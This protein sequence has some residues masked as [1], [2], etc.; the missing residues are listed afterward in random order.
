MVSRSPPRFP[1]RSPNHSPEPPP[2]EP[3]PS[4]PESPLQVSLDPTPIVNRNALF[5]TPSQ[6]ELS[7]PPPP[8]QNVLTG[9]IPLIRVG[10]PTPV[11]DSW[12][13]FLRPPSPE[14]QKQG[15]KGKIYTTEREEGA[16]KLTPIASRKDRL[17][18]DAENDRKSNI[19]SG[20]KEIWED[21]TD[22][23]GS[24]GLFEE[25][26]RREDELA[27][28][29]AMLDPGDTTRV[30]GDFEEESW[31]DTG[32]VMSSPFP[33]PD[34][35]REGPIAAAVYRH[36]ADVISE[37][38]NGDVRLAGGGRSRETAIYDTGT[39][40]GQAP[41]PPGNIED[42]ENN[43]EDGIPA[44]EVREWLAFPRPVPSL[45][46]TNALS[47]AVTEDIN[48]NFAKMKISPPKVK[49][50][51]SYARSA[52]SDTDTIRGPSE[53]EDYQVKQSTVTSRTGRRER[54]R[55]PASR[56]PSEQRLP[57]IEN[58]NEEPPKSTGRRGLR[59][60]FST[61][62]TRARIE[63]WLR[64]EDSPEE[65][66]S[67]DLNASASEMP[68]NHSSTSLFDDFSDDGVRHPKSTFAPV[69][70]GVGDKAIQVEPRYAGVKG[71]HTIVRPLIPPRKSS[72][73]LLERPLPARMPD[74]KPAAFKPFPDYDDDTSPTP[75][76]P[77][78][79]ATV[80]KMEPT[81]PVRTSSRKK[82]KI[83]PV[84]LPRIEIEESKKEKEKEKE[85]V[86]FRLQRS[87]IASRAR[88]GQQHP[89]A[90]KTG[91]K[92]VAVTV[93]A[94]TDDGGA[95]MVGMDRRAFGGREVVKILERCIRI[96]K[97]GGGT[98]TVRSRGRS[99]IRR[100]CSQNNYG[101]Q[102]TAE[103]NRGRNELSHK[104]KQGLG[105]LKEAKQLLE[106]HFEEKKRGTMKRC[107]E[108]L[109]LVG[110]LLEEVA[111]E[112]EGN[113]VDG[114]AHRVREKVIALKGEAE[115]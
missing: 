89:L 9:G 64:D 8:I 27:K 97:E 78:R 112:V 102:G 22:D 19:A 74:I 83:H 105:Q 52:H 114:E 66:E 58:E 21:P 106:M 13:S 80:A 84:A 32:A 113:M 93:T 24:E 71:T 73:E 39:Y 60:K 46:S 65:A 96:G 59:Y 37:P 54:R 68:L 53:D 91:G 50:V 75:P 88:S 99:R 107:E 82:I 103:R 6:L 20:E 33:S 1:R 18:P 85:D 76:R 92:A 63:N 4:C 26:K 2:P 31:E 45:S 41:D 109:G 48:D 43:S 17:F 14:R 110:I 23:P 34:R 100:P 28:L 47:A 72:K 12:R 42:D 79:S 35:A 7:W 56:R 36:M 40:T 81:I 95:A 30:A 87:T 55:S 15:E 108:R 29:D 49:N 3:P 70:Y 62:R 104:D 98:N 44:K 38:T 25:M 90:P 51:F 11:A 5:S 10:A 57:K 67:D 69:R 61:M 111:T 115:L 16:E 86:L 101:P 77:F 94:T